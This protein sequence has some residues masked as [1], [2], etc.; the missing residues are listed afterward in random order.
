[1]KLLRQKRYQEAA[2]SLQQHAEIAPDDPHTAFYWALAVIGGRETR[3][4]DGLLVK[5]IDQRLQPFIGE[6]NGD[7]GGGK[8]PFGDGDAG[9]GSGGARAGGGNGSIGKGRARIGSG[10]ARAGFINVLLAIVKRGYYTLNG[11]KVPPPS[12]EELMD[13]V[14]LDSGKADDL[15]VHLDEPENDVWRLV[16]STFSRH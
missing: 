10:N 4:L 15:L 16:A 1:M 7:I 3:Q 8:V 2:K 9:I 11:F 14:T 12:V 13:E 5:K 6:G